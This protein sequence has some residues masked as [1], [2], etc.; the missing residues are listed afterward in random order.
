MFEMKWSAVDIERDADDILRA[1]GAGGTPE[2]L[3]NLAFEIWS[4]ADQYGGGPE[5]ARAVAANL[6][7]RALVMRNI[8]GVPASA[9]L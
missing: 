6:R 8:S 4:Q 5:F 2:I 9:N 1:F 7:R 3:E